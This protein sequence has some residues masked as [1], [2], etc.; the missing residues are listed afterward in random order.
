MG[1]QLTQYIPQIPNTHPQIPKNTTTKYQIHP[2][3]M[4]T[5]QKKTCVRWGKK[6]GK[7]IN[8]QKNA[9]T[10]GQTNGRTNGQRDST[11]SRIG[12]PGYCSYCHSIDFMLWVLGTTSKDH[13]EHQKSAT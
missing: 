10:N 6:R 4:L 5:H 3:N 13:L 7:R 2:S 1:D 12:D 8:G 11:R 9:Q